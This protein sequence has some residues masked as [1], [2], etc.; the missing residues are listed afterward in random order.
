MLESHTEVGII[1]AANIVPSLQ[2]PDKEDL[3]ENEEVHCK[4][5]QTDLAEGEITQEER[6][7]EDIL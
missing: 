6:D 4:S 7:P 3:K 1:T 5:A 2:K